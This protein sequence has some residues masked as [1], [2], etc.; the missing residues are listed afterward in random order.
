MCPRKSKI[1]RVMYYNLECVTTLFQDAY[2][3]G[4]DVTV[5]FTPNAK[6]CQI[7][8][9]HHPRCLFFTFMTESSSEDP[10]KW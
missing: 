2:F 4:G 7:I 9:T 3:K 8:C 10:T 5:V 1:T 6:H